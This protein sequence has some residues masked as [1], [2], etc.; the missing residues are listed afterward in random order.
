[1]SSTGQEF[2]IVAEN[3][4]IGG[5]QRLLI[6]ETYQFIE[7]NSNP[8]IIS[9]AP[10]LLGD[11]LPDL[12]AKFQKSK[13]LEITYLESNKFEQVKFFYKFIKRKDAPRIY[14][15]HSTTGAALIKIA[16]WLTFKKVLVILQI[17]QLISLSDKSQQR[18]RV[19]YSMFA[20]HVLFSSNQFLLEWRILLSKK[21]ILKI[22]YRK[23]LQFDRMGIY[24]PRLESSDFTKQTFCDEDVP[25][26]IFLSRVTSWKGFEKFKA[27]TKQFASE[28]LHTV[29]I[30][31]SNYQA[32]ILDPREFNTD[33][34][35]VVF[36]LSVAS[37]QINAGSVHLYPSDYGPDVKYPQSIGMN[38]LEMISQG[39]PSLI[40][41]EGFESWPELRDSALVKVVDW[42]NTEEVARM[43]Y[44]STSLSTEDRNLEFI[45]LARA[46][47]IDSHCGRLAQLM[48]AFAR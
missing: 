5:I 45:K 23:D 43:V 48:Q 38:V 4:R 10:K 31:S 27:I 36:N 26:L 40:S 37:L 30:T 46:V 41:S 47:S 13:C 39:V 21:R 25:H 34:S 19:I 42:N 15:T 14:I 17:H 20:N 1:M 3:L 12:D 7:W 29:A 32:D 16:S 35:H 6:D 22:V 11:H 2:V 8:Q 18:K 33:K 9:L 44:E 28:G 24:L